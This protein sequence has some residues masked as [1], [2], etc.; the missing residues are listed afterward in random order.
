LDVRERKYQEDG[1][2]C[3][4][5]CERVLACGAVIFRVLLGFDSV[6]CYNRIST[7]QRCML[8]L[9]SRSHNPEDI[10]LKEL[11]SVSLSITPRIHPVLKQASLRQ[12]VWGSGGIAL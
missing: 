3:N 4:E 6:P 5:V 9:S 8:L 7:F 1:E 11:S 2:N 10:D 12:D